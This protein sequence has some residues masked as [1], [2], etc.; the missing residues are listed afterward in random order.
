MKSKDLLTLMSD[1][2]EN[3]IAE[4]LPPPVRKKHRPVKKAIVI[5]A[6]VIFCLA[7]CTTVLAVTP[8]GEILFGNI[9]LRNKYPDTEENSMLFEEI[10]QDIDTSFYGDNVTL[11]ITEAVYDGNILSVVLAAQFDADIDLQIDIQNK[12]YVSPIIPSYDFNAGTSGFMAGENREGIYAAYSSQFEC[13]DKKTNVVTWTMSFYPHTSLPEDT[14]QFTILITGFD[15]DAG[16]ICSG[17]YYLS[18]EVTKNAPFFTQEIYYNSSEYISVQ[19]T[20]TS[21]H[22]YAETEH[23]PEP[24]P[25]SSYRRCDKIVERIQVIMTD[26]T[27]LALK[28]YMVYGTESDNREI[29][30]CNF[31]IIFDT[32]IDP[33]N[34]EAVIID[35]TEY[36]VE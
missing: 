15:T 3:Y 4:C 23:L 36:P 7:M 21:M 27:S 22:V 19:M 33:D 12:K 13:W 1:I 17:E 32:I 35:G 24:F 9:S 31:D 26:G 6:A 2:D 5:A 25:N 20:M 30:Q 28:K 14:Q 18:F 34:V 8:L 29:T 16:D 11:G 10:V